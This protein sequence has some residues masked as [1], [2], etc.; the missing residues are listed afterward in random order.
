MGESPK[1]MPIPKN[2]G[3]KA[4]V[5]TACAIP[6]LLDLIAGERRGTIRAV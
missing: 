4:A 5:V 1:G 3:K 6:W 2:R